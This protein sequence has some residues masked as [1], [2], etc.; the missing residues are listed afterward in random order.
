MNLSNQIAGIAAPIVT[1]YI[2][3]T[4]HSFSGAFLLAAVI[5]AIGIASYAVM[6]G[7]IERIAVPAEAFR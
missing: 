3:G 6:L 5:L 4:T 2:I 7:R 1:G